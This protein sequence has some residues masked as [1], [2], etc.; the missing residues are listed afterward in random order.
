MR[1]STV[2]CEVRVSAAALLLGAV[3]LAEGVHAE[4]GKA[5]G[6]ARARVDKM[7]AEQKRALWQK[8]ER[9]NRLSPQEQN[10]LRRL[11]HDISTHPEARR[12]QQVVTEY[13]AWL[14]TLSSGQRAELLG[15]A[16]S[17]RIAEIKRLLQEQEANQMRGFVA[18][19]LAD[20]D[21]TAI[22]HWMDDL[23]ERRQD[24][25]LR[26]APVGMRQ[27][28]ANIEEPQRRRMLIYWVLRRGPVRDMLHP[29]TEDVDRL[30][31]RL[32]TRARKQLEE[33]RQAGHL[34]GLMQRWMRAAV[35]S[36]KA[37]PTV[38]REQLREFYHKTIDAREREYLESLPPERMRFELIRMYRSH[39]FRELMESGLPPNRHQGSS[40]DRS[41]SQSRRHERERAPQGV[42]LRDGI[43]PGKKLPV[44][45][46]GGPGSG[47]DRVPR[48]H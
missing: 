39:Q 28:L 46:G 9:F 3:L 12:L 13:T 32:S 24:E 44:L 36:K 25:L 2:I 30:K 38:E 10:R 33:A 27:K 43:P 40:R 21:L 19:E 45:P 23:L 22:I 15:M 29:K 7:S 4:S 18:H 14:K 6:A 11:H 5:A 17:Q 34:D 37:A 48:T 1:R 26:R 31:S 41:P 20:E 42:P 16:P 47:P 35:S 8:R